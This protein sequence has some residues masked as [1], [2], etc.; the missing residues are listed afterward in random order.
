MRELAAKRGRSFPRT[1]Q[2]SRRP[3]RSR[4]PTRRFDYRQWIIGSLPA[5]GSDPGFDEVALLAV[6]HPPPERALLKQFEAMR[7][8]VDAR[9]IRRAGESAKD[10]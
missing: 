5:A 6:V 2:L 8:V 4:P 7:D 9:L 10:C 1:V 3:R